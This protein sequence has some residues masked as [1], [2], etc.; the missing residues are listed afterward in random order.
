MTRKPKGAR[1]HL[2]LATAVGVAAGL[3]VPAGGA[4]VAAA[5]SG[6]VL[7]VQGDTGNPSLVEN[8]NPYLASSELRGT[9]L[10]YEPLEIPSPVNGDYTPFLATG[11]N[12]KNPTT[13]V[14][15]IRTGVNWSDGQPLTP[16]DVVWSFDLLKKY[17]ALDGNG[18]WGVVKSVSAAGD[19]VTVHLKA[20]NVPFAG[21][22]AQTPIVPEHVWSKIANPVKFANTDPV[23]SGPFELGSF[24]PTGY[25]LKKNPLYWDAKAIAPSEVVFPASASNQSTNQLEVVSG[26]FDW[27]YNYLPNVKATFV[28]R[29]PKTNFYWFPPG[30]VIGLYLNLTKAPYNNVFFRRGISEALDRTLV[31]EKAVNGYEGQA[32]LSGLIL[33]NL[34]KWLDP[35]IPNKGLVTQ[36]TAKA[37]SD[38]AA[39]G[40][41]KKGNKLVSSSGAQATMTIILPGA[42]S[43]W[44]AAATE[45]KTEL[46]RVGISVNLDTPQYAAYS[47]AIQ[48]GQFNAAIGGYGGTGNPYTDF[49]NALNS[50]FAAPVGTP[51]AN[52]FERFRSPAADSAL[53]G[54]ARATT[55]AAQKKYVYALEQ[56]MYSEVPIVLMYYGGSWGL[57]ST[58]HFTGWPSASDPYTLPT[59]YNNALLVVVSRLKAS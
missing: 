4:G 49:N 30:G 29:S 17:P 9:F 3:L 55:F 50:S 39:A 13:L 37:M 38:F 51:T 33:P 48:S 7:T 26:K 44:V 43:D 27:A 6:A 40:Y 15:T 5:A 42:F 46:G 31:A 24:S 22:I 14:Y 45:V 32:S 35:A 53:A 19:Q 8:F 41:K 34:Q 21:T 10:M 56:I 58:K 18:I 20:P 59:P 23:V 12:F 1:R 54:L 36:N 47:S 28:A 16:A 25:T 11:Y 57:F 52:N 2:V